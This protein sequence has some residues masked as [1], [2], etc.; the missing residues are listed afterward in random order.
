MS[1]NAPGHARGG[2]GGPGRSTTR[3]TAPRQ[4]PPLRQPD[5]LKGPRES[6]VVCGLR[7]DA[8]KVAEGFH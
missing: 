5:A 2:E 1:V 4:G 3:R 8:L 7:G 6:C